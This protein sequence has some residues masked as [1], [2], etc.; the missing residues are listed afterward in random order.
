M[1]DNGRKGHTEDRR[2]DGMGNGMGNG[3]DDAMDDAMEEN[4]IGNGMDAFS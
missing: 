2:N 1:V 3:M 4:C